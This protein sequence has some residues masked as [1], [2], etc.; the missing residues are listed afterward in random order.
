MEQTIKV[1]VVV[2]VKNDE[3]GV[4]KLKRALF[5]QSRKPDEVFI[6]RAEEYGNCSRAEGR[7]IG[8]RKAKNNIIAV[9]DV[10]C[11]PHADWL[12][13]LIAPI[14]NDRTAVVVAGFYQTISKTPIQQA[15]A[16]YLAAFP[17]RL[18]SN[19]LPASRSI[20]FTK[21]AWEMVG[22]YPENAES[23]AEDLVFAKRLRDH[24]RIR[25]FHAPLALVDWEPP[26][27]LPEFFRDIVK[28]TKGNIEARY[29]P[30]LARNS[31]IF[32]R[33]IILFLMPWLIPI[34]LLWPIAKHSQR[35]SDQLGIVLLPIVQVVSDVA[36]MWAILDAGVRSRRSL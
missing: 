35:V 4:Q 33:W 18:D 14:E 17:D 9:T 11:T 1:S 16:P 15:I 8:I 25:M 12:Q 19:Y 34:Y 28:H 29:W 6:I 26:D 32:L 20:A 24:P 13:R 3:K 2:T 30:H 21:C 7:N 10:G 27:S 23:G 5:S 36:V 22:G 31:T